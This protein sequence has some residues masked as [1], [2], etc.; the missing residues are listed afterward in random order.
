MR[1]VPAPE[2]LPGGILGGELPRGAIHLRA[3]AEFPAAPAPM[4]VQQ[5]A[6]VYRQDPLQLILVRL[7]VNRACV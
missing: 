2:A 7:L 1:L 4:R 6:E 5:R 3:G